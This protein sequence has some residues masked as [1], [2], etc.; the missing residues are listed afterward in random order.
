[1]V[2]ATKRLT[3]KI[4]CVKSHKPFK[5]SDGYLQ[6]EVW[7]SFSV[8]WTGKDNKKYILQPGQYLP[9]WVKEQSGG[10]RLTTNCSIYTYTAFVKGGRY[11][12]N[13]N[14]NSLSS[15]PLITEVDQLEAR[16]ETSCLKGRSGWRRCEL[17]DDPLVMSNGDTFS[18]SKVSVN[19]FHSKFCDS[20]IVDKF[21]LSVVVRR[22]NIVD[23]LPSDSFTS[24]K[25]YDC[26]RKE[27][28]MGFQLPIPVILSDEEQFLLREYPEGWHENIFCDGGFYDVFGITEVGLALDYPGFVETVTDIKTTAPKIVHRTPITLDDFG[29]PS[30]DFDLISR[31]LPFQDPRI[32]SSI[33]F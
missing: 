5:S 1:M 18:Y 31:I 4:D 9:M 14:D 2:V 10:W 30:L 7:S 20:M 29:I 32:I 23:D 33:G 11:L 3:D 24:M 19:D 28:A 27:T 21:P 13:I 25:L 12:I 8:Q 15:H 16:G 6:Q 26:A 22:S 17:T